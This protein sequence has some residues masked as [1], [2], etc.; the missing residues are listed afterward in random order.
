MST[1]P[2][3]S[4]LLL[5][6]EEEQEQGHLVSVEELCRDCP[7]LL[8]ELRR[9]V[10]ALQ[11]M[12]PLLQGRRAAIDPEQTR[13]APGPVASPGTRS[14]GERAADPWLIAR[15]PT[16]PGY[17]IERELGRGGM[18]VV[19]LARHISLGRLVAL[20]MLL[21]DPHTS[22]Y[23][24][25]RFRAETETIA[26]LQ[27]PNIVQIYEV[28]EAEGRAFCA[29]EYVDG[30][31][32]AEALHGKAC[33][34]RLAAELLATLAD[35]VHAAHARGVIHRDLKPA[36]ILL[37]IADCG[38]R[39]ENQTY[40]PT[41]KSAI[42]SLQS[43][44]PKI[45]DFGLAKQL[46]GNSG[47]TETGMVMGTPSYMAPEQAAGHNREIGPPTDVYSLGTILYEVL[48]GRPPLLGPTALETLTQ[49][50][51]REPLPA[52]R[53]QPRVPRD[54]DTICLKC[55]HKSPARRYA[56][57]RELAD[58]LR[59][60]LR[61]EPIRA[62]P[63]GAIER[64]ARWCKRRPAVAALTAAVLLL[65]VAVMTVSSVGYFQT[66]RALASEEIQRKEAERLQT[67]AEEQRGEA[68]KQSAAA[69]A[70]EKK[71]RESAVRMRRLLYPYDMLIA[72]QTWDSENGRAERVD[73]LLTGWNARPGEED[74][75][76]FSWRYLWGLL[77][78][79]SGILRGHQRGAV[80]GA[81]LAD[82]KLVT[83]DGLS[84]LRCWD[85]DSGKVLTETPLLQA[86][87][88][89]RRVEVAA[90][91][92]IAAVLTIQGVIR[93]YDTQTGRKLHTFQAAGQQSVA[94][95]LTF[96]GQRVVV[97]RASDGRVWLWDTA[98]GERI[99]DGETG[100]KNEPSSALAPDGITLAVRT[101][102]AQSQAALLN[103]LTMTR[104]GP[105]P[106]NVT[107]SSMV[108]SADGKHLAAG[109]LGG[110]IF[111][112]DAAT[113]KKTA[114]YSVHL[115]SV[116]CL[117][118]SA[119]GNHLAS[120]SAEGM[121]VLT[122]LKNG[123]TFFRGKGH[124]SGITFVS[125]SPDGKRLASGSSDGTVRIWDL[126]HPPGPRKLK[127]ASRRI[128]ALACSPDGKWLASAQG[129]QIRLWD[130]H[131]GQAGKALSAPPAEQTQVWR[132]AFAPDSKRLAAGDG[133][134]VVRLWNI[135][136]AEPLG[137]LKDEAGLPRQNN[138]MGV[139]SLAFSPDG[140][141]LAVGHGALAAYLGDYDQIARVWDVQMRKVIRALPHRNTV[142][143]V[144][145]SRDGKLLVTGCAD[146]KVR[147]WHA[148]TWKSDRTITAPRPV[149]SMALSPDSNLVAAGLTNGNVAVWEL[150]TG[151]LSFAAHE[152]V[153]RVD[154]LSF[155]PDGKS[156]VSAGEDFSVRLWR[157]ISE[158]AQL[159][160][161][162]HNAPVL[163]LAAT[164]DG[165]AI[166]SA[167]RSGIILLWQAP[168]FAQIEAAGKR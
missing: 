118:F 38:L 167:D 90:N 4:E 107:I 149:R 103:L 25:Q 133:E 132:I 78:G 17:E 127:E 125:L 31:N 55:L 22:D 41:E 104:R 45:T 30:G 156:I 80:R 72:G 130:A 66:R 161:K 16:I 13:E 93:L 54:L 62:R 60:F 113:A 137:I 70:A 136:T 20:K 143:A 47:L 2:R 14:G 124:T 108:F 150:G 160:L 154:A 112:W 1:D 164:P 96:D 34:P 86:D 82:G 71:V 56:S 73:R 146:K 99:L 19:Y 128:N 18:G 97:H 95:H 51:D 166:A 134:G 117:D 49:V 79:S 83:I 139:T 121:V 92:T 48:T 44:I 140:K 50:L 109:T 12:N 3:V 28:G 74:L 94:L 141:H 159:V 165:N 35:A 63:V 129:T 145:F 8:D 148:A 142:Y 163:A 126:M 122:D 88:T 119:D 123:V 11:A 147:T 29:L 27:H 105:M 100:R 98:S 101:G 102:P 39:I 7:H 84:V 36:N 43:A 135:E 32:L 138:P 116:S 33:P 10:T 59:R 110:T 87:E 77:H 76:D 68:L 85:A 21:A 106:A 6:W 158:R 114:S 24:R 157:I 61:G 153:R 168:S 42:R 64:L 23:Q 91:G 5:Q 15:L 53:L 52:R 115:G 151:A 144:C 69:V 65:L 26:R 89:A 162:G 57:A 46:E 75:R 152:H 120:G 67:D 131:T 155:T 9:K 58:D 37:Q 81:W 111:H 40:T